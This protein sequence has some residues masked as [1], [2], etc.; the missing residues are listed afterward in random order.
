MTTVAAKKET[1]GNAGLPKCSCNGMYRVSAACIDEKQK[2]RVYGI[3][4]D[5]YLAFD[6]ICVIHARCLVSGVTFKWVLR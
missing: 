5:S 4:D 3:Q 6:S 2:T 1:F